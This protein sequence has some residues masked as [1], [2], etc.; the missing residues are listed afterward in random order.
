[1]QVRILGTLEASSGG[2]PL[3]LGGQKQRTVLAVLALRL[4]LVASTDELIEAGWGDDL[5]ANP[6]NTL[7]YQIAQLRKI[8]EPDA[9][10][11]RHLITAKRGYRL[12]PETVTTDAQEFETSVGAARRAFDNGDHDLARSLVD[13]ALASWRG[14]ALADFRDNEFARSDAERLESERIAATELQIDIALATGR[15]AEST[16]HLAQLTDEHPLREGLWARRALAL[17]RSGRQSEALRVFQGARDALAEIGLDPGPELRELE[18]RIIEQDDSLSPEATGVTA[19]PNNLPAAPNRLIGRDADVEKVKDLLGSHRLVTLIGSGGA[20]KTRLANAVGRALLGRYPGGIWLVPL[21]RLEDGSLLP[22]EVGR[23]TRMRENP[24][25]AVLDTLADHLGPKRALLVLDNC[26]HLIEPVAGFV[27]DLLALSD[28][29]SILTTSQ[30]TLETSGEAVFTVTPLSIPGQTPSIYHPITEIDAV[31]LF[32]ERARDAGAQVEAWDDLALAAVANIVSALDGLPL[33]L[34]LAAAHTRSMSLN[35]I[36]QGLSDRFATLSRGPRTAP[37]RQRSLL[38]AVEWSLNLLQE[39]QRT[40]M[41]TLSIFTGGFDADDAAAV[42][43]EPLAA[44]RENLAELVNRSLLTRQSDVAGAARFTM[45]ESL[46]HHGVIA[47]EPE[48]LASAHDAHLTHF[49]EFAR[50]AVTGLRGPDQINWLHRIDANYDNIRAALAWSL[51]NGS[52]DTGVQLAA[53]TGPYWDWRGLLKEGS[54]WTARLSAAAADSLMPG[55]PSIR[56][57]QAFVAWE[58]GELDQARLAIDLAI[59][60]AQA[61]DDPAEIAAALTTRMLISRSDGDLESAQ[62]DGVAIGHAAK[63]TGDP[64]LAAWAQSALATVFLAAGDLQT[65]EAHT[66]RSLELFAQLGDRRGHGWGLISLAQIELITGNI[67]RAQNNARAA[68]ASASATEDDRTTLWALEI[69][70]ETAHRCGDPERSARLWGA[71]QPLREAR[72][73]AGPVS[74]LSEPSDLASVLSKTLGETFETLVE[75]S[76]RDPTAVIAEELIALDP[77]IL[78]RNTGC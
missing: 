61:L 62:S 17:Y 60:Y 43:S 70:T 38:G 69:L 7:Q 4:G 18:Q 48:K 77:A 44:V 73:L 16:P 45:L 67:D 8:I 54:A 19:T 41:A 37:A 49:T 15:H 66:H 30:I 39:Q 31:A 71:A 26:E 65:A 29:L 34:E 76:R 58:Y 68:L 27:H 56:V 21:D 50:Q 57:I 63:A 72:G 11:P 6:T 13:P 55:L 10:R 32:I 59:A 47:L 25:R 36:A 14:P 1:M 40:L 28:Q 78:V 64:W 51:D 33:A 75:S 22:A 35:E 42:T 5:P 53:H 52:L 3:P 12:D 23:V 20:G 46:R 2:D 9:A 24:N 74:K